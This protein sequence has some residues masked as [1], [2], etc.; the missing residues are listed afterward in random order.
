MASSEAISNII[1]HT[2]YFGIKK[3]LAGKK[4]WKKITELTLIIIIGYFVY[5]GPLMDIAGIPQG[6]KKEALT[7]VIQPIARIYHWRNSELQEEDK[8]AIRRLFGGVEPWYASHISDPP[9]SQFNTDVFWII[10]GYIYVYI[11]S[12]E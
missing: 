10:W 5:S 3:L 6:D 11:A 7:V 9:K 1:P 8:E 2:H 12:W 4:H